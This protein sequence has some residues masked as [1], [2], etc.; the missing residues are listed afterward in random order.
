MFTSFNLV[1]VKNTKVIKKEKMK[2]DSFINALSEK[3]SN[4]SDISELKGFKNT[5]IVDS[6]KE[7]IHLINSILSDYYVINKES[8]VK[9]RNKYIF[10]GLSSISEFD[11][12]ITRY[13]IK[14]LNDEIQYVRKF[15][16]NGTLQLG[17]FN[18]PLDLA[19]AADHYGTYTRLI[20]WSTS[21]LIATLFSLYKDSPGDYHAILFQKLN[22]NVK[23]KSLVEDNSFVTAPLYMRYNSMLIKLNEVIKYRD[24]ISSQSIKKLVN[25]KPD[26]VSQISSKNTGSYGD[27]APLIEKIIEYFKIF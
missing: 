12:K 11:S 7:Y 6:L 24:A 20:D 15:E 4:N 16:E 22:D 26:E 2:S 9:F 18:N 10:R 19:A 8:K 25:S 5:Y 23:L 1:Q 27:D 14:K 17:Q 3:Y 13:N 21:P